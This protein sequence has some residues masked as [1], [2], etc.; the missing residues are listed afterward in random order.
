MGDIRAIRAQT[1]D[2]VNIMRFSTP[3]RNRFRRHSTAKLVLTISA[4]VA[5]AL[6]LGIQ[7]AYAAEQTALDPAVAPQTTADTDTVPVELGMRFTSKT[8]GAVSAIRFYKGA[9]NLGLHTGSLWTSDG[10]LLAQTT[11]RNESASGWQTAVLPDPVAIDAGSTYV[12]SYHAPTGRYSSTSQDFAAPAQRGDLTVPA[13]AGVYSYGESAFPSSTWQNSNYFVDVNFTPNL[14][15]V[16]V[17]PGAPPTEPPV[18]FPP[19][20]GSNPTTSTG[21]LR[22]IDGGSDYFDQ[23]TDSLPSDPDYFPVG[24]W[25]ESILSAADVE[26]DQDAGLNLYVELTQ[27]SDTSL[28]G[29]DGPYAIAGSDMPGLAGR[30][31]T[32]EADMWGGPGDG[33]WTG[34]DPGQ[35]PICSPETAQCGY[36]IMD[37]LRRQIEPGTLVYANYGKGVTFWETDEEAARFVND[38]QDV[39]SADNYWF[40]DPNICGQWE[41][42][43]I[44]GGRDL[45]TEECRLAAN[46]GWT[47]DRIRSLV[48]PAGS[49]PVW[50]FVEVGHPFTDDS[51]PTITGPEI[52]AAVWSS[53]IH[54][55][56][57]VIYFNHNFGGDCT[58]QHVLRDDCGAAVRPIVSSVNAQISTL[59][60]VLNAPYLDGVTTTSDGIDHMTKVYDGRVYIFAAS[61]QHGAQTATITNDCIGTGAVTVENESRPV[62]ATN[63]M[64]TDSFADSNA[65]HIYSAPANA[66]CLE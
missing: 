2:K 37:T 50:A 54:G 27:D 24:V 51:A 16:P 53:I 29:T 12:V 56:Q 44:F 39:V 48:E 55:A 25:Y 31:T 58:S 19:G 66:A 63:G 42:G 1:T 4:T 45:T 5:L 23:F 22:P 34:N 57:G 3:A 38:Y 32:D 36:T 43:Q 7:P 62:A 52:R 64:F 10:D 33:I 11:F 8:G 21:T 26:R 41:G 65:V 40:T 13:G 18:T 9:P 6:G 28:L 46:Y 17:T 35:G 61:T 20:P 30:L 49:V 15:S 59:A 60:P 14:A 47:I